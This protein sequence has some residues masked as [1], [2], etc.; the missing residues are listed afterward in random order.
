MGWSEQAQ[1]LLLKAKQ[2]AV[3]VERFSADPDIVDEIIGFHAQQTCEKLLNAVL[4]TKEI[5]YRFTHDL[6]ELRDQVEDAGIPIPAVID[7]LVNLSAFSV[8][9]RYESLAEP[10][11]MD[12]NSAPAIVRAAVGWAS[13]FVPAD[14]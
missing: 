4:C 3:A 13:E 14:S 7:S 6:Q 12:R 8:R 5:T 2:D 10:A 1:L 9:Y 11:G